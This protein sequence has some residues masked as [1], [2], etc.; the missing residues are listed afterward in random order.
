[1][2]SVARARERASS[3]ASRVSQWE[4]NFSVCNMRSGKDK[5]MGRDLLQTRVAS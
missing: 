5:I 3:W 4:K 2:D 1:M